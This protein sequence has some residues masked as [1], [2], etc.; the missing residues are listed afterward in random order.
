M[1][2]RTGIQT[3]PKPRKRESF[4]RPNTHC[5]IHEFFL[6]RAEGGVGELLGMNRVGAAETERVPAPL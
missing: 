1:R 2:G 3:D 4:S 6:P 5:G